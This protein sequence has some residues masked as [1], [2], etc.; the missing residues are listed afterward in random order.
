[1]DNKQC[2]ICLKWYPRTSQNFYKNKSNKIDGLFPYCKGCTS[3][4]SQSWYKE[5]I[6]TNDLPTLT[7]NMVDNL[8]D[9]FWKKVDIK[10]K[11]ECWE[12]KAS[13][14]NSGY[15]FVKLNYSMITTHRASWLLTYGVLPNT[16]VLHTCDNRKCVN[17]NHLFLG[18]HSENTLDAVSKG[19]WGLWR[20]K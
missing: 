12:W 3:N 16:L 1:M 4:K 8:R 7:K 10:G 15:G 11:D 20:K 2:N 14:I 9:R 18:T 17:P 6:D 5:N 19:R 13:I